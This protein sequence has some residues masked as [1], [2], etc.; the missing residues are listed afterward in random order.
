MS[1]DNN[2]GSG[3]DHW[4]RAGLG[5]SILDAL[6]ASGKDL[7]A[8]T[9]DDLAPMDNFHGGGKPSTVRLAQLA[10]LTPGLRVLDV[11][12]GLGGPARTLAVEFGCNVTVI[13]LTESYV[14]AAQELTTR[15]GL[16]GQVTH[17]VGNALEL[18]V[19]DGHFD[20]VW[21]QNS[22]MNIQNKEL[23]YAGFHRV[24]RSGGLLALGEPMA[25]PTQPPIFP[26]MWAVDAATSFLRPPTEMRALIEAT[27]FEMRAWND[28]TPQ[29]AP[30]QPATPTAASPT[31]GISDIVMGDSIDAI[32]QASAL[33][34][35]EGRIVDMQGLFARA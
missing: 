7:D 14:Q 31:I 5:Q 20:V 2:A 8:L 28:V 22:G 6:A 12:G 13:D 29:P 4:G 35:I 27:G 18:P 9:I 17:Q 30:Q 11:G 26:L 24:L 19:D 1:N 3:S 34:R 15:L 25:G 16:T 33:N 21:T 23:L 32:A 10:A